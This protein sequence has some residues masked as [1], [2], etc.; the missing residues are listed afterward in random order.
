MTAFFFM[1]IPAAFWLNG[2]LD[3]ACVSAGNCEPKDIQWEDEGP[4]FDAS[5]YEGWMGIAINNQNRID[6]RC[7]M[8]SKSINLFLHFIN[9]TFFIESKVCRKR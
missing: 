5:I 1:L 8:V 2:H 4:G 6:R 7:L 3:P 9:I